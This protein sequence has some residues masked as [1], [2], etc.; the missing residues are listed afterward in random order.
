[1]PISPS[2]KAL[3]GRPCNTSRPLAMACAHC[4]AL[5]AGP[6]SASAVPWAI[7]LI[8][9]PSRGAKS[10]FTPQSTTVRPMP[11]WRAST[12]TAAPPARKFSTI[13]QVTSLGKA[14]TPRAARPWSPAHTSICGACSTGAVVPRIR[15]MRCASAS[16]RPSEPSGLVLLSSARCRVWASSGWVMSEHVRVHGAMSWS[17]TPGSKWV[18]MKSARP[19]N[20]VSSVGALAPKSACSTRGSSNRPCR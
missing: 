16:M 7:L 12:L 4:A 20:T 3:P 18:S 17:S 11:C 15:P 10:C 1:M 9:K 2:S 13:C 14:E 19:S 8:N 5:M 6:S